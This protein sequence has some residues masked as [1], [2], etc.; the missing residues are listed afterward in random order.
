MKDKWLKFRK[1]G[2][3]GKMIEDLIGS[4]RERIGKPKNVLKPGEKI[5]YSERFTHGGINEGEELEFLE[6]DRGYRIKKRKKN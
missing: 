3:F 6:H 2:G 4:A 5:T 1:E